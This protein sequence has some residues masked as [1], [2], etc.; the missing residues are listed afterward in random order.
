MAE[1][2]KPKNIRLMAELKTNNL[3]LMAEKSTK[4][5]RL[6]LTKNKYLQV[7]AELD[8][9]WR[10]TNEMIKEIQKKQD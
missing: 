5:L 9:L 7:M 2:K 6:I 3:R 10:D 4:N 1:Q 8:P